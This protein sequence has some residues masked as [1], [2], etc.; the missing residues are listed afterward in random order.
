MSKESSRGSAFQARRLAVLDRDGWVCT[1][2]T[3]G[4][5]LEGRDATVDHVTPVAVALSMSWSRD[6]IDA[7]SNLV[8][9]CRKHNGQKRDQISI[10]VDY[11][12]PTWFERD[13]VF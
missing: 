13:P 1:W 5:Q 10:R 7:E 12:N 4:K 8:A 2:P 3:C 6:E 9:M 11:M